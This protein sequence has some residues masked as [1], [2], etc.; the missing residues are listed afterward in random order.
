MSLLWL[1]FG[2]LEQELD[3]LNSNEAMRLLDAGSGKDWVSQEA[4]FQLQFRGT[5]TKRF[6]LI[7]NNGDSLSYGTWS[8]TED[9]RG[10]F[11][12]TLLFDLIEVDASNPLDEI[13]MIEL[14]TSDILD[15]KTGDT[16]LKFSS[17][18]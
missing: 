12:D 9:V 17:S 18:K 15:L 16:I 3:I 1:L 14:I 6:L 13:N 5:A 10:N 4:D 11:T 8:V 2:C 7:D